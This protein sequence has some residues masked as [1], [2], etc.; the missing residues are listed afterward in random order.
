M[1]FDQASGDEE[2]E[3]LLAIRIG[4]GDDNWMLLDDDDTIGEAETVARMMLNEIPLKRPTGRAYSED[5]Q[6]RPEPPYLAYRSWKPQ[7]E[8]EE[9][10]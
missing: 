10:K 3:Q 6:Q 9:S 2:T 7:Q 1:E 5:R 4:D 8:K